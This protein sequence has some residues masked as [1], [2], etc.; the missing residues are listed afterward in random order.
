VLSFLPL[1]HIFERLFTVFLHI[2]YAYTVNFIENLDT[3]TQNLREVSPTVG[4][5]VPRVWEKYHSFIKIKMDEATPFKRMLFHLAQAIGV[6]YTRQRIVY[7]IKPSLFLTLAYRLAYGIIFRKLK[8]RLGFE[9]MRVAYS[10]AAPI[11]PDVLLFF[12]MIGLN[13]VEGYGQTE[14]SGITS[15][16]SRESFE[17]GSVGKPL[18]GVEV[19]I[20]DDGEILVKS[21]GVFRG[22]FKDAE[23]T[24][25][26]LKEGWLHSG[27]LGE[28]TKDGF[29]KIIDRKKDII[30]TAGGKN[31]APQYIE[32]Q[33][34]FSPY[35]NDAVVIGDRR[36]FLTALVVLDEENI[37]KYA[38]DHK[39]QFS[40]YADLAENPD[41]HKLVRREVENVNQTL[42]RVEQV[43]KFAILP[44]KLYEEDGQVTP[45]MKVKRKNI[46]ETYNELIESMYR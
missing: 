16:N 14:G 4:Y 46:Q 1:C 9:R 36:K 7:R 44:Q 33:L 41:I 20:A 19:K 37:A 25:A 43:R 32:N 30:I 18:P 31:I 40:T 6:K 26:A 38:R 12:Q 27:D 28:I 17:I 29:L 3:V 8:E 5:A 42:S 24:A 23:N 21:P 34:K 39:I 13:I 22:Y 11:S 45:T 10:G 35:I 2:Q 15:V